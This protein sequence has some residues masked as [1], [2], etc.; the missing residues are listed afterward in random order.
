MISKLIRLSISYRWLVILMTVIVGIFGWYSF[1]KLPIDAVPDITNTQVQVNTQVE[2][3][4]PEEIERVVTRPVETALNGIPGVTEV[5]SLTRFGLSQVTV[6][7]EDRTDIYRARQ[8]VSERLQSVT[9]KLPKG[10]KVEMGPVTSG[11]GE[12]YHYVIEAEK[13]ETGER[14]IKQLMEL[15]ALQDW[16]IKPRLLNVKGVAEVNS[17]GGYEKQFV[18]SP[19][20]QKMAAYGLHFDDFKE[21]FANINQNVGGGYV[22]QTGDQFLIQGIGVFKSLADIEDVTVKTLENGRVITVH[23]VASVGIGKEL[24]TGASLHNGREVVVG[25]V[26][27]LL[28]ENSRTVAL[29]VTEQMEQVKKSLPEGYKIEVVYNRSELVNATLST[30][31]HNLLM[32]A[33]LVILVLFILVG[34]F[35]AALI[36]AI[37]IPLSLLFT[38]ILMR[39]FGISGNLVSLGALDFGIIV[40]GAVIVLDNCVR[41]VHDKTQSLKRSLTQSE[42]DDTIHEATTEIRTSAGFGE[43]IVVVVFLPVFAFVGIEGKMFIPMASTFIFAILGALIMS[44]TFVPALAT[45]LLK[46]KVEDKEPWIMRKLYTWYEPAL[47]W[48]L[49][50]QRAIV[51]GAVIA[52]V[53]GGVLFSRLGGEFLPQLNEGSLAVQLIRPV[54]VGLSHSVAMEEKSHEIIQAFPE[55]K[56]VF[57]RIGTAEI[58][59]DPMGPNISD[60]FVMLKPVKE[61]P[62]IDGK[63]RTKDEL[64]AAIQKELQEKVPGQT[65]LMSQPIQLR[66][67]ELMEGTRADVSLKIFGEDQEILQQ[68]AQE[69]VEILEKIEG[70]GDVELEGKG[71]V[72]VLEI[73]PDRQALRKL[74]LSSAEV[75]QTVSLAMGGEQLG[76]FYEGARQ[77][78]LV[79]RLDEDHRQDLNAIKSLPVGVG[80]NLTKPLH[81]VA[82]IGFK[83]SHSSYSRE[84]TQRRLAIL[85]NPRGR[86][87]EGFVKEAQIK[88]A[89]A[90]KLP[91]GYYVQWGGNFKNLQEAKTRLMLLGPLA[92]LLVVLMIFAAFKNWIETALIFLCIPL[93]LIGGVLGL[94]ISGLPFSI[95]AGVG[96]IAL[97]GIA[98]LNGVV[99]V[100]Y[101]NELRKKGESGESLVKKGASLRLRPV[102]MTALVDIFGFL[103]MAVSSSMGAEVQK[104]LASVII[105]GIISSTLLTLIVLPVLYRAADKKNWLK[106]S[107]AGLR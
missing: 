92:L 68:K 60:T 48:S 97:S 99:L 42:L 47:S 72:N 80:T 75:M 82:N 83:E 94:L 8:W 70:S 64:V 43:L 66:F 7:F 18:I 107:E 2:A 23:D 85:I 12:I 27:M 88:V 25:T 98:V 93:A 44:F 36:T 21:A 103:P 81:T 50:T 46:G 24:R 32:G 5:R 6:V 13:V 35:R 58:S 38:F 34:N 71:M 16:Y 54:S 9:D 28:G 106:H 74:G 31:E 29:R 51:A 65:F 73:T 26:L 39:R 78:P 100:S 105:G 67:N 95:S 59:M 76:V 3:L 61:W 19:N 30:V 33:F 40:D 55:V 11:L 90:V 45:L 10:S 79:L 15:R 56:D 4:G 69:I 1:T 62:R 96:F 91:T 20:P 53:L 63:K 14:R 17:I 37:V 22:E 84:Q 104:P 49:K 77:V 52:V 101:F 86:D 57:A 87:T 89:E 102:L 41:H